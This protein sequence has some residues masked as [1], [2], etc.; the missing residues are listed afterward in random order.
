MICPL[1]G[2]DEYVE[3]E[4][5]PYCGF[6][7]PPDYN[8]DQRV[9][10]PD[11]DHVFFEKLGLSGN[12]TLPDPDSVSMD[13]INEMMMKMGLDPIVI[14]PPANALPSSNPIVDL[15]T[16]NEPIMDIEPDVDLEPSIDLEP[17]SPETLPIADLLQ[18]EAV[19]DS[20]TGTASDIEI[21]PELDMSSMS[22]EDFAKAISQMMSTEYSGTEDSQTNEIVNEQEIDHK[23]DVKSQTEGNPEVVVSTDAQIISEIEAKPESGDMPALEG[24]S[25]SA[26]NIG[27]KKSKKR[28]A[29]VKLVGYRANW[30]RQIS[31]LLTGILEFFAALPQKMRKQFSKKSKIDTT[32]RVPPEETVLPEPSID[33]DVAIETTQDIQPEP[34]PEVTVKSEKHKM[35]KATKDRLF[36]ILMPVLMLG[37]VAA[38]V[39][40]VLQMQKPPKKPDDTGVTGVYHPWTPSP[41]TPAPLVIEENY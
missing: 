18:Q 23:D 31:F 13:E 34:I 3:K 4:G 8:D 5:C 32:D 36:Y 11:E 38:G 30:M 41:E 37:L 19:P 15:N 20:A 39:Y 17:S 14:D 7:I 25:D 33:T 16:E 21:V 12:Q 24:E 22:P 10:V 27:M 35:T 6:I 1:C 26:T 28:M 2:K 29:G 9:E 40:F